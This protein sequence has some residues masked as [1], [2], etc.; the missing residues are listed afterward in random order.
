MG[1]LQLFLRSVNTT[2]NLI[3]IT[4]IAF[5]AL[6]A[7]V[8]C[9]LAQPWYA[10]G[11]CADIN[12]ACSSSS[13]RLGCSYNTQVRRECPATCGLCTTAGYYGLGA[14]A[15]YAGVYDYGV[16]DYAYAG[17]TDYWGHGYAYYGYPTYALYVADCQDSAD[18]CADLA[19]AG[20]CSYERSTTGYGYVNTNCQ[21]SCGFCLYKKK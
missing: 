12:E 20:W 4:M 9:S 1:S 13:W 21:R 11:Y 3:S 6:A 5:V 7:L 14:Y 17:Y 15:G 16:Y 19:A 10:A 8:S 18:N 2:C